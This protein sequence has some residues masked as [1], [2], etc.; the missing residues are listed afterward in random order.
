MLYCYLIGT[1]NTIVGLIFVSG[2]WRNA[3]PAQWIDKMESITVFFHTKMG[4][5]FEFYIAHFLSVI[6]LL[7]LVYL[8]LRHR[9]NLICIIVPI[10]L[11]SFWLIVAWL[12][13][14]A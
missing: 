14:M 11:N 3:L 9:Q 8:L 7:Y 12:L 1:F 6:A 10:F 2:V 5:Y 4:F 13:L